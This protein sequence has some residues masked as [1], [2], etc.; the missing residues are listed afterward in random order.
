MKSKNYHSK[1]FGS[2]WR[3]TLSAKVI[4]Y[5]TTQ[6]QAYMAA[7]RAG[8]AT[9]KNGGVAFA[10]LHGPDGSIQRKRA[11]GIGSLLASRGF[12]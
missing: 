12:G 6:A 10:I 11:F 9:E 8:R 4:S 7:L 5:H 3:L 2:E 1:P